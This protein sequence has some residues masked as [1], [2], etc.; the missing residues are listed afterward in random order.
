M[1]TRPRSWRDAKDEE[2][3]RPGACR[4]TKDRFLWRPRDFH[5]LEGWNRG[6]VARY[7]PRWD[8]AFLAAG[9]LHVLDVL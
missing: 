9:R 8:D 5:G 3:G 1:S 7:V 4:P 2:A 6:S